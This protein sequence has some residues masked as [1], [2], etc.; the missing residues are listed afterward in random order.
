MNDVF[1][2]E[3][4]VPQLDTDFKKRALP[5]GF[6]G[7]ETYQFFLLFKFDALQYTH[8]IDTV[9]HQPGV[10]V[11]GAMPKPFRYESKWDNRFA[12]QYVRIQNRMVDGIDFTFEGQGHRWRRFLPVWVILYYG[13][14]GSLGGQ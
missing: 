8:V 12:I 3:N 11:Q 7:K 9:Q 4:A 6:S 2:L 10:A 13:F 5:I 14:G 1:S